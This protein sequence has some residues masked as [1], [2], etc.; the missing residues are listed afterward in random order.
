MRILV[1][2][3]G[4]S[5]ARG[6]VYDEAGRKHASA[7]VGNREVFGLDGAVT[8]PTSDWTDHVLKILHCLSSDI[9]LKRIAALALTA[10]RSSVIPVDR[11]GRALMDT[12][13]WQDTR[14]AALCQMLSRY[15]GQIFSVTGSKVNAVFSGSRMLWIRQNCPDIAEKTE[16]YLNIPEYLIFQMTGR[17]E[18]DSSYGCRSGLMD[19]RAETWSETEL[20]RY[21]ICPEQLCHLNRPGSIVGSVTERFARESGL[22][23]GIPVISAGGDQ[24]CAALGQGIWQEGDLSIVAGTGG[25]VSAACTELPASLSPN[26][27]CSRSAI[28]GAFL[29]EANLITCSSAYDSVIRTLYGADGIDY[30]AVERELEREDAPASCLVLPYF[31]GKGPPDWN[32]QAKAIFAD[33]T[34]STRKSELLKATAEGLFLELKNQAEIVG[35][36]VT[37]R[38]IF[39][40]GG[41]TKSPRLRQL[42]SDIFGR[43]IRFKK[44][45]ETT[46]FGA[47]LSAAVTLGIMRD[48]AQAQETLNPM[49]LFT[50]CRPDMDKYAFYEQ[51]R[52]RMNAMY[53]KIYKI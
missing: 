53:D 26:V 32:A 12:V 27:S 36:Y 34:L 19:L 29:L 25:Y 39:G 45:E 18:A 44:D 31:Q 7:Q 38:L 11:D 16:K 47:F 41:M 9:D 24:Q 14:N 40:S 2:D 1:L 17:Y 22:P 4:S 51:K 46:A 10:Q 49:D 48:M 3:V 30:S 15:N 13:M 43:E 5:S 21:G 35:S 50:V 42:M 37:P 28:P 8:E 52:T 33:V 20:K 6:V 23:A